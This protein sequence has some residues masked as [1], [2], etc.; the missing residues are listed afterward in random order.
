MLMKLLSKHL[1]LSILV[2]KI[3]EFCYIMECLVDTICSICS[4]I[5]LN[6]IIVFLTYYC[7]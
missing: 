3:H 5:Y 2:D 4:V 6:I 7:N 1:Y